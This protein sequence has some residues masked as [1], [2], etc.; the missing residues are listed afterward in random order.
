M[1]KLL[2]LAII[3]AAAFYLNRQPA[4]VPQEV[5]DAYA[6]RQSEGQ[7]SGEGTVSRILGDDSVGDRHQRF[8]LT[9]DSGRTLLIAHNIDVAPRIDSLR[10]GDTVS[11]SGEYEWN[12]RG[13][14]VHW[15]HHDPQ[16]QHEA[17]WLKHR[18][19]IYQ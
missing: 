5:V 14:V 9:L 6:L 12:D 11:F 15:T 3:A 18:G 7:V 19:R 13:G 8:I 10:E 1:K 4:E 17:G 2:L 16:G